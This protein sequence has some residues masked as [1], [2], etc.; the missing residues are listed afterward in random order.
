MK[1]PAVP[2]IGHVVAYEYLWASQAGERQDGAKTYPAALVMASQIEDGTVI[3]YALG[4]SHKAPTEDERALEVPPKL[5]RWLGLDGKPMWIYTDQL[6]VFA[7]PGPD[8]RPADHLSDR[9]S[10]KGTCVIGELPFDWYEAVKEHL[11]ESRKLGILKAQ[12]R[13]A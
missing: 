12:K 3:T 11:V 5:A 6:N 1:I 2:P 4:I 7:W 10:A 13:T 8:L 9:P